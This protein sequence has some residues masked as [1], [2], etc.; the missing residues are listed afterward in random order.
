[1]SRILL[2]G[3]SGFIG[4]RLLG[5]LRAAGHGVIGLDARP[6]RHTD[7]VED[8]RR[9]NCVARIRNEVVDVDVVVHFAGLTG[10]GRSL[11]AP[12]QH[13]DTHV[14]GTRHALD[15][16]EALGAGRF[17][18][19]S[20]DAVYGQVDGPTTEDQ[21][22]APLSPYGESK[23]LA[24]A[25]CAARASA[26]ALQVIVLR[27]FSV[28]GPGQPDDGLCNR[29]LR[30]ALA[31]EPLQLWPWARDFTY[32]DEVCRASAAAVTVPV[33]DRFRA[34]NIGSGRPVSARQFVVA[35]ERVTRRPVEASF[36]TPEA[37]EPETT[38][39][40]ASRARAELAL[41]HPGPFVVG[42][43]SQRRAIASGAGTRRR[44]MDDVAP[45]TSS[46]P[47]REAASTGTNAPR[48]LTLS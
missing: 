30:A 45:G 39:A 13:F 43:D 20:A 23:A 22:L 12:D 34:Y 3:S 37:G 17:V 40:D 36:G 47:I 31:G 21:D 1:M 26:D 29:S 2:T 41:S 5:H 8:L 9:H 42:L 25:E 11:A 4:T 10:A 7:I 6:A 16:A 32:I 14:N 27:P 48:S 15:L 24:E 18:L 44:E 28:Y 46:G 19:A 38:F 33:R 35:I